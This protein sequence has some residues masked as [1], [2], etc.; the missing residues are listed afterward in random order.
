M[1][2]REKKHKMSKKSDVGEILGKN[3]GVKDGR[4]DTCECTCEWGK[5]RRTKISENL[6]VGEKKHKVSKKQMSVRYLG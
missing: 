4:R 5:R 1:S 6:G 3:G 2:E